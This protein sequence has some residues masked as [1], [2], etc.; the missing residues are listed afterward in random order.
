MV[1]VDGQ[2]YGEYLDREGA[3]S[4]AIEAAKD[5]HDCGPRS[6]KPQCACIEPP[7]LSSQD[8]R[9]FRLALLPENKLGAIVGG[10][11]QRGLSIVPRKPLRALPGAGAPNVFVVAAPIERDKLVPGKDKLHTD[12]SIP[13]T[14][15]GAVPAHWGLAQGSGS[16]ENRQQ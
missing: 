10:S 14:G 12:T 1:L 2:H 5:A 8:Y 11:G 9:K 13:T 7:S 16:M 6:G 15:P 3:I 4:D